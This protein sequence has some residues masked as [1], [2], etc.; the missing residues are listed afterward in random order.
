MGRRKASP[1]AASS[2]GRWAWAVPLAALAVALA[3]MVLDPPVLRGLRNA[4]F[5]QFQRWHPRSSDG[6]PP[7]RIVDIDD[8]SLR[9]VG[10]WPWRRDQVARLLDAIEAAQPASI[11]V[12]VLFAER[13]RTAGDGPA[14][15]DGQLARTL[16]AGP[17]VLG[18]GMSP[19]RSERPDLAASDDGLVLKAGFFPL[20][21]DPIPFLPAFGSGV[22]NLP[23]FQQAA[24]G[25]GAMTF[26][27]DGD[28]VIRQVPLL[29]SLDGRLV[30]SLTAEALR[31]AVGATHYTVRT[32]GETGGVMD[33]RIGPRTVP[34]DAG[35]A[36]WVHY[37]RHDP[38]R[39][40]PAWRLLAHEVPAEALQG[41]IVLVG[42][43]AQGLM[44]L[45]F[46]PLGGIIPGVEVHA[47]ALEQLLT[48]Q[49]LD[50]PGWVPAVEWLLAL[51]GGLAVAALAMRRSAAV[52]A[53]G[54]VALSGA[55][56]LAAWAAFV[57]GHVL[58]DAVA[59]TLAMALVFVPTTVMRHLQSERRQRWMKQTFSRYVSP[60]L[61][62]YLIAH[63]DALV[64]EGRRQRCS[65]VFT[66]LAGFTALMEGMDPAAA[67]GLVNAYLDRMIAIAFEHEGTLDRIVG[68][69]VAI[70]FSAPVEQKD[71]EQRALRCA[72][73]MHAFSRRY[74]EELAAQGVAF[75]HTR[76]GV[77]T[78]EVT[79]GNFGGE[80]IFD[81]RALG[82][83]VNTAA[84]LESANK[85][86]GTLVC[87]SEATLAG[88]PGAPARPIGRL[89]LA[90]RRG[91][92]MAYE[93]LPEPDAEYQRA[94]E[95]MQAGRDEALA[96]FEALARARPDDPLVR[97]HLARL[98][99]GRTGDAI[100]LADK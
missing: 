26:I 2:G 96:A 39:Y 79:V 10:Q 71:H 19:R 73:A 95:L 60:N 28:G 65:F 55:V 40:I 80:A 70:M 17:V 23:A 38:R 51:L 45:R 97:L 87:V 12:D 84:R 46:G 34:T 7:V 25:Q 36:L 8:E 93:P 91:Y 37:A 90:G 20:G 67:V 50:R 13:D 9:R 35:G 43:S 57:R 77:H 78:G 31:V 74:V 63:P 62:E 24:A 27:P 18:F 15:P 82:D 88:C 54:F 21:G 32:A 53:A 58:V 72:L 29:L 99:A 66:D 11:A 4:G 6:E 100:E 56:G 44:D 68:D 85:H 14:D 92:L 89:R 81:Y 76:I 33:V 47:Q 5:D 52:S 59:P 86:L 16:A 69:A 98:H 49:P 42:T 30:P 83:P 64:L 94:F 22:A 1:A 3:A 41:R 75:S 48:G 61:V